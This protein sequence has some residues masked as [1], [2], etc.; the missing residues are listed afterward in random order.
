MFD[1]FWEFLYGLLKAVLYCIDFVMSFALKLAGIEPVI[2]VGSGGSSETEL[3]YYFLTSDNVVDAFVSVAMIGLI[4]I[5]IFTA[6]SVARSVA[7]AGEGKS[8][9]QVIF[10]TSK[11]LLYFIMIPAIMMIG[12][13]FVSAVMTSIYRATSLGSGSLGSNLFTL[14]ADEAY[15]G[16]AGQKDVIID[17][18]RNH[19]DG[20]DR[21]DYYETDVVSDY[22]KLSKINYFLGYAGSIWILFM[23]L[24]SLLT[25]V[26]RIISLVMLFIAGPIS[27]SSAVLDEGARFKLWRDQVMNR[28]LIA[29]GA[30]ISLN[31]FIL[32]IGAIDNIQFFGDNDFLNGMAR[33]LFYIGG[34][35][36]C[37]QGTVL[38]G[39]LVNSGAGSQ[40][41]ADQAHT[42]AAA[43]GLGHMVGRVAG[44]A[45][46]AVMN[47]GPVKDLKQNLSSAIHRKGNARR[48]AKDEAARANYTKEQQNKVLQRFGGDKER[49]ANSNDWRRG[50]VAGN[51]TV[52]ALNDIRDILRGP[53]GGAVSGGAGAGGGGVGGND[54]AN[55]RARQSIVDNM[56]HLNR[57]GKDD[58]K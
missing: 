57:G 31:I 27:A 1:W 47:H 30:L 14:F 58:K 24:K 36:A 48:A 46:N 4:L 41:A 7:R 12:A 21:Y 15:K 8:A 52:D 29:Y 43:A 42:M 11:T 9:L 34:A 49:L 19:A 13:L 37:Q 32:L 28:F 20:V 16:D 39:N 35:I 40:F 18:F 56:P 53:S 44:S 26:E 45:K 38:I 17:A 50:L 2:A 51:P 10:D 25:F 33:L 54:A 23:I 6:F 22:F 5:F 3:T 55:Q